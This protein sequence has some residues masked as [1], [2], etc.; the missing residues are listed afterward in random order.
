MLL[1]ACQKPHSS[2]FLIK[3]KTSQFSSLFLK[4]MGSRKSPENESCR[5]VFER[6]S[7]LLTKRLLASEMTEAEIKYELAYYGISTDKIVGKPELEAALRQGRSQES[8][9]QRKG[10]RPRPRLSRQDGDISI[11]YERER[12]Q[13]RR[14][15]GKRLSSLRSSQIRSRRAFDVSMFQNGEERENNCS[16]HPFFIP[17]PFIR[18]K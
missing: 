14:K 11:E 9:L 4:A 7:S 15:Q 18:G 8:R 10:G 2:H 16:P 17:N 6:H 1:Q 5:P 12:D 13:A 3:S